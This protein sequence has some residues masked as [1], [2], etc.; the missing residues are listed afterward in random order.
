M[1]LIEGA[2][3]AP[4]IPGLIAAPDDPLLHVTA[5]TGAPGCPQALGATRPLARSLAPLVPHR[6]MLHVSGCAKG[7]AHPGRA[8]ATLVAR[9]GDAFDLILSDT[10]AGLPTRTS[11]SPEA[12]SASDLFPT[13]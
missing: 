7:C 11:I 9:G 3:A 8:D 12:L 6:R 4:Q 2:A 1:V 10:A 13:G 5:C